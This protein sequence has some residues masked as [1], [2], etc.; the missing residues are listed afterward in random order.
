MRCRFDKGMPLALV[1]STVHQI[2]KGLDYC[3][4]QGIHHRDLK[5]QNVLISATKGNVCIADFGTRC[6]VKHLSSACAPPPL[7]LPF[8]SRLIARMVIGLALVGD[9]GLWE[10]DD[11]CGTPGFLAP[12]VL[13]DH[14]EAG[15]SADVW[16]VGCI[17]SQLCWNEQLFRVSSME[18]ESGLR[19]SFKLLGTP[20]DEIWPGVTALSGWLDSYAIPPHAP[21]SQTSLARLVRGDEAAADLLARLLTYRPSSRATPRQALGHAFF[22]LHPTAPKALSSYYA[23]APETSAK[24]DHK[25][26]RMCLTRERAGRFDVP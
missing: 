8:L 24:T 26:K 17:L 4:G 7:T 22:V 1:R 10:D 9:L 3:H 25:S 11:Y 18:V 14:R 20:T 19:A 15:R 13:L 5:C 6:R 12:E 21:I 16:A 2:L 23:K